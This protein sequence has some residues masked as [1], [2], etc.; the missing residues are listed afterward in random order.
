MKLTGIK[1]S[2]AKPSDRERKLS[3]GGG[4]YLLIKPNGTKTWRYKY[5]FNGKELTLALGLYPEVSLKQARQR[6]K[7]ARELLASGVDPNQDKRDQKLAA[8]LA[9][10]NT[11]GM[12]AQE[13]VEVKL[14]GLTEATIERNTSVL[15]LHLLPH[16]G[17]RPVGEITSPEL[18]SV[19]RR[20][21]AT[22]AIETPRRAKSIA[23]Q[24]FR[25]G[26][27]IGRCERDPSADIRDALKPTQSTHYGALVKPD[28]VGRLMLAIDDYH[29]SMVVRCALLMSAL[30]FQ[31]PGNV[32]SMEW[33]E[34][35]G[36]EWRIPKEKSKTREPIIVPL[37]KQA[38]KVLEEIAPLSGHGRYV[39]PSARGGSRQLSDGAVRTALRSMGYDRSQMT[40]HGFRAMARTLLDEALNQRVEWIE[41]QL[42]HRV[43]DVHGRAY[44]RTQFLPERAKM[45][46]RWA[47]YL[48]TVRKSVG[49]SNVVPMR[50]RN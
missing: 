17:H 9:A 24:V 42:G 26:I 44:N 18:L 41:M 10:G 37:S 30:T 13:W 28:E 29:G 35:E 34:I 25:Y 14:S 12:V 4:L 27:A 33:D 1:V 22:G 5:R 32:R 16:L 46:Q 49:E 36:D 48:D 47:N 11:F 40:A 7:A 3:D 20:V 38:M 6:H 23:G 2:E 43:A 15:N 8:E 31:R 39:F 19:L 50:T 21:E 45:M